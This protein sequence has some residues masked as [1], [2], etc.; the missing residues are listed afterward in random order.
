MGQKL[1]AVGVEAG[2]L[3]VVNS[4]SQTGTHHLSNVFHGMGD[5]LVGVLD[6]R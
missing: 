6:I 2:V 5:G 3:G 1:V 4:G